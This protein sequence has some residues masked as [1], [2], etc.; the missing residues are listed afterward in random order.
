VAKRHFAY[1]LTLLLLFNVGFS[2]CVVSPKPQEVKSYLFLFK[3]PKLKFYDTAFIEHYK[4]H[5]ALKVLSAGKQILALNTRDALI[6]M[7]QNCLDDRHFVDTYLH[8][9]YPKTLFHQ[10]LKRE[11]LPLDNSVF[12]RYDGGFKQRAAKRGMY[13]IRYVVTKQKIEFKDLK[14]RIVIM[15]KELP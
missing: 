7:N 2:G 8:T 14:N 13:D 3:S 1:L 9:S 10:I 5:D 15:L 4:S 12:E 6:C 11:M